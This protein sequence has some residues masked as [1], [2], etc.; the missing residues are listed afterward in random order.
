MKFK[1]PASNVNFVIDWYIFNINLRELKT[2]AVQFENIVYFLTIYT[3]IEA[4][5]CYQEKH[6]VWDVLGLPNIKE[7]LKVPDISQI[8]KTMNQNLMFLVFVIFFEKNCKILGIFVG[9]VRYFWVLF[10]L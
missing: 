9:W 4:E 3:V 7:I 2:E 1:I 10:G 5:I 6:G 8:N